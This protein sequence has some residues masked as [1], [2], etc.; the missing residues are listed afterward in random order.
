L[1]ILNEIKE[2]ILYSFSFYLKKN[3]PNAIKQII[4]LKKENILK[5]KINNKNLKPFITFFKNHT[6]TQFKFLNDIIVNDTPGNSNRFNI[7]YVLTSFKYNIQVYITINANETFEVDSITNIY[8]SAFWLEREIW[9]LFGI[10]FKKNNNLQRLLLD[11][12]FKGYP[13]RKDFP[14]S[15]YIHTFY[16]NKIKQIIFDSIELTQNYRLFNFN[17]N[18]W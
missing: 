6:L 8:A 5:I 1:L 14:L 12:G 16:N 11:Y 10:F 17:I 9:D 15:G 2:W 4:L 3:V 18:W 13:L 7:N